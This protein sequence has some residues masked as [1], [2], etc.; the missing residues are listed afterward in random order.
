[1]CVCVCVYIAG[2]ILSP[3]FSIGNSY[4]EVSICV[5]ADS[6]MSASTCVQSPENNPLRRGENRVF[7]FNPTNVGRYVRVTAIGN[8]KRLTVCE[9]RVFRFRGKLK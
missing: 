5:S 2:L 3:L 4:T 6:S 7:V 8:N 1:M 9:I